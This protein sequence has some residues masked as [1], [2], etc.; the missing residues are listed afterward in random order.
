MR[1]L[2]PAVVSMRSSGIRELFDLASGMDGVLNL[3]LGEPDGKTPEHVIEA[4]RRALADGHTGYT[5]IA[6]IP[7]LRSALTEKARRVNDIQCKAEDVIVTVGAMSGLMATLSALLA[8]GDGLLVPNPGWTGYYMMAEQLGLDVLEYQAGAATGYLPDLDHVER[9]ARRE[10]ARVMIVNTPSNP[11]GAVFPA[12]VVGAL[13]EIARRHDLYVLSDE[14]YDELVLEGSHTSSARFDDDGRVI[15]VFSFSKTH[16]MPG[17]RL[18]YTIARADLI[19][20]I[21]KVQQNL[22]ACP[23]N[24]SQIAA[25]AA[26][27]GSQAHITEACER[28]RSRCAALVAKLSDSPLELMPPHGAFYAFLDARAITADSDRLAKHLL[29]EARVALAPGTSFGC[30]GEGFLRMSLTAPVDEICA[31]ITN[32]DRALGSYATTSL[33]TSAMRAGTHDAP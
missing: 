15:S 17:W 26:L 10:N 3:A 24:V 12:A 23:P 25:L 4:G 1:G 19:A 20:L 33:Q 13:V 14:P 18:G 29:R 27:S 32:I 8:A 30:A 28:Y 2:N 31:A 7:E 22:V 21:A 6:G 11:T 5:A 16:A 9:L